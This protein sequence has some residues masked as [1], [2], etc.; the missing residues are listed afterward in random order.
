MPRTA[1]TR[2]SA[3]GWRELPATQIV[4]AYADQGFDARVFAVA[5]QAEVRARLATAAGELGFTAPEHASAPPAV[6]RVAANAISLFPVSLDEET[7]GAVTAEWLEELHRLVRPHSDHKRHGRWYTT[8]TVSRYMARRALHTAFQR[9]EPETISALDPACGCGALLAPLLIEIV[10]YLRKRQPDRPLPELVSEALAGITAA[11]LDAEAL[12]IALFRLRLAAFRLAG[13]PLEVSP[14]GMHCNTLTADPTNV[15]PEGADIVVMNPPY[16]G[17]RYFETLTDPAKAR[18]DLRRVFGWTDDLYAHFLYRAWD[19]LKPEGA[20]AAI[21]SDTYLTIPSKERIR[22]IIGAH[23][24]VEISRVPASAFAAHVNTCITVAAKAPPELFD[25]FVYHDAR[26]APEN[27]WDTMD[28]PEPPAG[29]ERFTAP[30]IVYAD[31]QVPF[32]RPTPRAVDL[33]RRY[34]AQ[35]TEDWPGKPKMVP[36]LEVAPAKDCGINSGNVRER[37]FFLDHREG[38]SRLIQ[39]RQLEP[40]IVRW[41]SPNARYRWVDLDYRPDPGRRGQGRGGRISNHRETWSFRGDWHQHLA[42]ERILLRQT[43]DDLYASLIVNDPESPTFTD[44]TVHTII[45]TEEGREMGITHLYLLGLLNSAFL[46]ELYHV[47]SQEEGRSQA[48]VKVTYVNRLPIALPTREQRG[49]VED[50]AR[51]AIEAQTEHRPL[52]VIRQRLNRAVAR[53]YKG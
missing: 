15:M 53:I 38:L 47:L 27:A 34:L 23:S 48:Q 24:L 52:G 37:L 31:T 36:L 22:R 10:T 51:L 9:R 50:Y 21:T 13:V 4:R 41:D 29:V 46:N 25:T 26:E 8:R 42:P 7:P 45:V 35:R 20:L 5:L 39:G 19:W 11:D 16:L 1:H 40:F 43:E 18:D 3:Q 6:R 2:P 28:A 30:N 44:N 17:A 32:F 49:A 33:F 14:R 12:D